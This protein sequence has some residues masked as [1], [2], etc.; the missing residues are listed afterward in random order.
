MAAVIILGHI[1]QQSEE[2]N[3]ITVGKKKKKQVVHKPRAASP[4]L[5]LL[6]IT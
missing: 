5:T 4:N 2:L 3:V 1:L 6:R